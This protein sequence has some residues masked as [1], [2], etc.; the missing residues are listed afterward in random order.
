MMESGD[1][2]GSAPAA[3]GSESTGSD[4]AVND[5]N[6]PEGEPK[7]ETP[8][9]EMKRKYK[10]KVDGQEFE[11]EIDLNDEEGMKR[12]LQLS[13]AADK[14]MSEAK[15]DKKKAFDIIKAFEE[16]PESMLKRLGPKGREIAEKYLL[17]QIQDE[18]MSK[19]EKELRDLRRENETFKQAQER[20]KKDRESQ[21]ISKKEHEYAESF[22]Q[23]IITALNKSGL[24]KTPELVKRMA[25]VM[26]KNLEHGLELTPD[27]LVIEVKNDI[28]A[29]L[30]SVIG[31]ADGEHLVAMFGEDVANKIR[32]SDI[33]KLQERQSQVHQPRTQQRDTQSKSQAP[34]K[35]MSLDEWR[36]SLKNIKD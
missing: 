31:D 28:T 14:R 6:A 23:T 1:S 19:E 32:R 3:T 15:A 5:S 10:L 24:P 8:T 13:R 18:M 16:D 29:L 26:A 4:S 11:E 25:N 36:E 17:S 30:K 22:Q 35:K 12:R 9:Q 7:V 34:Q 20:E 2:G 27:D 33:K 21:A